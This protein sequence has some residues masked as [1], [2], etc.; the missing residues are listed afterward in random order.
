MKRLIVLSAILGL[1]A[2]A[3]RIPPEKC[4]M[5]K[6]TG[7]IKDAAEWTEVYP[8]FR[9]PDV[10]KKGTVILV[11][12]AGLVRICKVDEHTAGMLKPG[13]KVSLIN[14]ERKF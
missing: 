1:S 7:I 14:A 5:P 12:V 11:E 4:M 10:V 2:C 9:G 6:E 13:T 3:D 8:G